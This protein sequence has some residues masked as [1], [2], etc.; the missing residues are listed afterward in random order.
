MSP[1]RIAFATSADYPAIQPD[2]AV[3]AA[4]LEN[5]GITPVS[6]VWNDPAVDWSSFEAV[7]IRTL[8]DY[9][10]HYTPFI[11]WLNRLD[12]LDIPTINDSHTLRWN[13]DKRYLL[14]F[15]QRGIAIIPSELATV[16]T[17]HGMLPAM[18]AQQVVIKPTVSGGA[19]QTLRGHSDDESFR[20]AVAHLPASLEYLLQPFVPE[21]IDAGECSLLYFNGEFSHA[22][23][24]RP[25][26]GD[27]RVQDDHGGSI[28]PYLPSAQTLTAAGLVMDTV[29]AMGHSM[30]AY[31]RVDGVISNDRFLLMELELI[32]PLLYLRD[33]PQAAE[34]FA[35]QLA[36]QL[37]AMHRCDP[38]ETAA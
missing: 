32:E 29:I 25:A 17:L 38:S 28:D 36:T 33:Q 21:I 24:K 22:V 4:T 13:S 35:Q 9:H 37:S 2:D 26:P 5:L 20:Q 27:Y 12:Q 19:W 14:E 23:I 30:P 7:L 18:P 10:Q 11:G 8:W 1:R 34:R 6:C 3:L 31:A 16:H 15:A